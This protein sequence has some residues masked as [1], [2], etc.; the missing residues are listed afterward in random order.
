M[1][2]CMCVSLLWIVTRLQ[3]DVA[4]GEPPLCPVKLP[5][6]PVL[7]LLWHS[8]DVTLWEAQQRSN[9][10]TWVWREAEVRFC[11]GWPRRDG[12]SQQRDWE[13]WSGETQA[14][15]LKSASLLSISIQAGTTSFFFEHM[16]WST[17]TRPTNTDLIYREMVICECLRD[18]R[19]DR[20]K[21]LPTDWC[22]KNLHTD[23]S[24]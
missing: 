9:R 16:A 12:P 19:R 11:C 15:T 18:P 13:L 8:D 4:F 5:Q 14:M 21:L 3:G 17:N 23:V 22:Q 10:V 24:L 20:K 7:P 2:V 1:C 6:P